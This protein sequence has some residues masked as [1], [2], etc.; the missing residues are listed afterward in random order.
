MITEYR[1]FYTF[2]GRAF[3]LAQAPA[4]LKVL[5]GQA[6]K[7]LEAAMSN[8]RAFG[9]GKALFMMARDAGF[10]VGTES[11]METWLRVMQSEP[12]SPNMGPALERNPRAPAGTPAKTRARK[13][14]AGP[15]KR[16]R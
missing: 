4:C 16:A 11:G 12:L 9:M 10:E 8:P 2:L 15:P 6:A 13:P 5:G 14:K 1:A 3:G 7:K